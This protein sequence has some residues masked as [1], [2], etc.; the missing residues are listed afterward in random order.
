MWIT[1]HHA[2]IANVWFIDA[3]EALYLVIFSSLQVFVKPHANCVTDF[4]WFSIWIF[5][6]SSIKLFLVINNLLKKF[7]LNYYP[8]GWQVPKSGPPPVRP[9]VT[10][11]INETHRGKRQ[12]YKT[13]IIGGVVVHTPI[14]VT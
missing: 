2:F 1:E 8:A 11:E 7:F 5:F 3:L 6:Q 4:T 13:E 12:A 10:P 14:Q 9:D